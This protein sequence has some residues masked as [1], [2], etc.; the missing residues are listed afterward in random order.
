MKSRIA[1]A[2]IALAMMAGAAHAQAPQELSRAMLGQLL[3]FVQN[4]YFNANRLS[5]TPKMPTDRAATQPEVLSA[6][7]S[8]LRVRQRACASVVAVDYADDTGN[9]FNITCAGGS[10]L[11]DAKRGK[12]T[13]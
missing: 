13:P 9:M 3:G 12:I 6:V 2:G 10:Y 5:D 11:V 1:V 8:A 7:A 4:A